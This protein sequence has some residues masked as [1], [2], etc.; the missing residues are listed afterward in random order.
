MSRAE[1]YRQLGMLAER[2]AVLEPHSPIPDLLRWAVKLGNMPFRELLRAMVREQSVLEDIR[3][4]FG[5][6]EEEQQS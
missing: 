4:Q 3:R 1:T 5:I 6:P 2:L